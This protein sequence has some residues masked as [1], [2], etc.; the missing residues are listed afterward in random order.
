VINGTANADII[1]VTES[2]TAFDVAVDSS[3][4]NQNFAK[5]Q[6]TGPIVVNAQAGDDAVLF[7]TGGGFAGTMRSAI[8]RGGDGQ[9]TI[10]SGSGD[11]VLIGGLG[12][13]VLNSSAGSDVVIGGE[14]DSAIWTTSA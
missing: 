9:D 14:L 7:Q 11:D 10:H 6:I 2:A 8:I 5:T 12:T 3:G 4:I 13:D 1:T